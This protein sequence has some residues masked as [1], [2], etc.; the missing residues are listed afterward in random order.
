MIHLPI[1]AGNQTPQGYQIWQ[2]GVETTTL[3]GWSSGPGTF[4]GLCIQF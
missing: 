4:S 3:K 2:P 1:L